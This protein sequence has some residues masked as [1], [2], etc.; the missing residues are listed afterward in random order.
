MGMALAV[1]HTITLACGPILAAIICLF[2]GTSLVLLTR[3]SAWR[4]RNAGRISK[5]NDAGYADGTT[6]KRH[7]WQPKKPYQIW[8]FHVWL[9]HLEQ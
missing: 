8:P 5:A 1:M 3:L 2:L 9:S 4:H 7:V 6:T